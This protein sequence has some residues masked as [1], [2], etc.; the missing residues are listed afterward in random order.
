MLD[1]TKQKS[2]NEFIRKYDLEPN[3]S[4]QVRKLALLI[5]DK[6]QKSLHNFSDSQRDLLEAGAL[7]H[8]IG[9]CISRDEHNKH[10]YVLIIK[11][12]IQ[13]FSPEEVQ[14]IANIARYHK[15]KSPKKHH[16]CFAQLSD[17]RS[18]E[19][20]KKLSAIIRLADGLDKSRKTVV[21]D[22]DCLYDSFSQT[23]YIIL[24]TIFSDI[25]PEIKTLEE[26]KSL[27]EKEFGIQVEFKIS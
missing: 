6:T 11:E 17:T 10:S 21:E 7:L 25:T 1:S 14:I 19:L 8:D 20:V 5:F 24:N 3:H 27:F 23:L 18:E 9:H 22:L 4:Q 26:K 15:G 2:L 12:K 16:E 13:G